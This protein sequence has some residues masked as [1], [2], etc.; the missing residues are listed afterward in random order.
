MRFKTGNSHNILGLL[1]LLLNLIAPCHFLNYSTLKTR[2]SN[3]KKKIVLKNSRHCYS[4]NAIHGIFSPLE[5]SSHLC[6]QSPSSVVPQKCVPQAMEIEEWGFLLQ[7]PMSCSRRLQTS[8]KS[9]PQNQEPEKTLPFM[10]FHQLY[11]LYIKH[12]RSTECNI[13]ICPHIYYLHK[14]CYL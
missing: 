3:E 9:K 4:L 13:I 7:D 11:T 8:F 5:K 14:L 1:P 2:F 12:N 10:I 6:V